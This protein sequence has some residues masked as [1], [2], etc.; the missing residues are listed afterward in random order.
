MKRVTITGDALA[1][2][3]H[4]PASD[5]TLVIPTD[6][7]ESARR[8]YTARSF[9]PDARRLDIDFAMHGDGPAVQW[10]ASARSG[11]AIEV[12]GPVVRHELAENADWYLLAGDETAIP[13]IAGLLESLETTA[14]VRVFIEV[15]SPEEKVELNSPSETKVTWLFRGEVPGE[16]STLLVKSG[17]ASWTAGPSAIRYSPW[18]TGDPAASAATRRDATEVGPEGSAPKLTK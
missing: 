6:G 3:R 4:E 15:K 5:F 13:A 11:M 9:D 10:A 8:H 12:T 17:A 1:A 14:P 16:E 2:Y 7:G 18:A